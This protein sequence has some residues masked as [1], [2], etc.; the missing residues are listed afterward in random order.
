MDILLVQNAVN[1]SILGILSYHDI[2][3]MKLNGFILNVYLFTGILTSILKY[4]QFN[5]LNIIPGLFLILTSFI[6]EEKVG[7]GDGVLMLGMG[8]WMDVY[9]LA[10]SSISGFIILSIY[11][12]GLCTRDKILSGRIFL[13]RKIPMVPFLF[14]GSIVGIIYVK[15]V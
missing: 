9:T 10:I 15:T 1:L 3:N 14:I 12:I 7:Y 11:S 2:R 8:F 4:S 6:T 5:F 13:M